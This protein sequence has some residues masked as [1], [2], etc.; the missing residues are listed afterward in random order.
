MIIQ[1]KQMTTAVAVVLLTAAS[2]PAVT[3]TAKCEADRLREASAYTS[4]LMRADGKAASRGEPAIY[5]KCDQKFAK[6]W[7]KREQKAAPGACPSGGS[8]PV[9]DARVKLGAKQAATL[10][11]GSALPFCGDGVATGDEPCDGNDL[12]GLSCQ[13]LGFASGFLTCSSACE[14]LVLGC[15]PPGMCQGFPA[16]GQTTSFG[17]GTDG[18]VEAGEPLLFLDNGDGTVTDT[19][20]WLMWEKK[21]DSG[22]LHDVDNTYRWCK[23]STAAGAGDLCAD[24]TYPLDGSIKSDFIDTLNDVSGGGQNCFAGHCDWRLPNVKELLGLLDLENPDSRIPPAFHRAK[25]CKGCKDA[26]QPTCSCNA[27]YYA[28]STTASSPG[29]GPSANQ[30]LAVSSDKGEVY[31]SVTVA[32]NSMFSARAVRDMR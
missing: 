15:A 24:A 30:V 3:P 14:L 23:P 27:G 32:K 4:C 8:A 7:M 5:D 13:T 28:S 21:D 17:P 10:L 1:M 26:S 16:T 29:P 6:K 9:L 11:G 22:G 2:A 31:V 12:R 19:N 25:T 20:T 18:D